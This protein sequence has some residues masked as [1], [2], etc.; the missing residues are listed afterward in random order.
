LAPLVK[1]GPLLD[2]SN[3]G[4]LREESLDLIHKPL[5]GRDSDP[6]IAHPM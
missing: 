4:V 5:A 6:R 2:I 3:T 1:A